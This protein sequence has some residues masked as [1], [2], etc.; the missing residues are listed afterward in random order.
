MK[1]KVQFL[2][3]CRLYDAARLYYILLHFDATICEIVSNS[4]RK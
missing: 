1:E 3:E 2:S 4:L